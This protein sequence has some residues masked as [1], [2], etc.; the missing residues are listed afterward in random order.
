MI[1]CK[2][3]RSAFLLLVS[4]LGSCHVQGFSA[5]VNIPSGNAHGLSPPMRHDRH[6]LQAHSN[7]PAEITSHADW[8]EL[9]HDHEDDRVTLVF[10]RSAFC[11][12]CRRFE[13]DWKRKVVPL[14]GPKLELATADFTKNRA[15]FK[16][17]GVNG[18]PSVHFYYRGQLLTGYSCPP[19][20]FPRILLSLEHYLDTSPHELEFEADMEVKHLSV[21]NQVRRGRGVKSAA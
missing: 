19:A 12:S 7:P 17:L 2:S 15:L 18:L 10:F 1:N 21:G 6:H 3:K 5:S 20:D 4:I 13:L 8:L 11:K 14:A 9:L 16:K